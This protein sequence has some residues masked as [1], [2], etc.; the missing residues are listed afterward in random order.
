MIDNFTKCIAHNMTSKLPVILPFLVF[1][2]LGIPLPVGAFTILC[3]NLVTD[4][5]PTVS[6]V[7]E[8]PESHIMKRQP[9]NARTDTL[10]N[11]RLVKV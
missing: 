7:F 8:E 4:V 3:I 11:Q 2:I 10:L 9:H 6:L 5:L 1:L